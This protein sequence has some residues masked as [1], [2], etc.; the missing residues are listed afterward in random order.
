MSRVV[1]PFAKDGLWPVILETDD[2]HLPASP[3]YLGLGFVPHYLDDDHQERWSRVF[4]AIKAAQRAS[5]R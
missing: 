2:E 5:A 3:R 4:R 1:E